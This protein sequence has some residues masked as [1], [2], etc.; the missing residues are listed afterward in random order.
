MPK[1]P[2]TNEQMAKFCVNLARMLRGKTNT[3]TCEAG[4]PFAVMQLVRKVEMYREPKITFPR[5][6][7]EE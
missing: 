5:E 7:M 1:T 3:V 4:V 2:V 6:A